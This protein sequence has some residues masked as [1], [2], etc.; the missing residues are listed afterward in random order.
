MDRF[1]LRPGA[2]PRLVMALAASLLTACPAHVRPDATAQR[3]VLQWRTVEAYSPL[4]AEA[5]LQS[6]IALSEDDPWTAARARQ[7]AFLVAQQCGLV[8]PGKPQVCAPCPPPQREQERNAYVACLSK[9][10]QCLDT[11]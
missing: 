1:Q 7:D 3:V 4:I 10:L 6:L 2:T 11:H 9:R 5:Y 8:V